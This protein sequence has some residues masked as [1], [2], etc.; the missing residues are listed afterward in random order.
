MSLFD[1][2]FTNLFGDA[3]VAGKS[4]DYKSDYYLLT[5]KQADK[6]YWHERF[7]DM[8]ISMSQDSS[9]E[10]FIV[11]GGVISDSGSGQI[12]LSEGV[13]IGKD[14]SGNR[15][16]I[17]MPA[18]TNIDVPSAWKDN[19]QLWVIG[20]YDHKLGSS[21][22]NH[23]I[24]TSYHYQLEDTYYGDSDGL[25][26]TD[27]DDLFLAADPG[28]AMVIWGSFQMSA[29]DSFTNKEGER[30]RTFQL[31]Q[32]NGVNT[33]RNFLVSN[34]TERA[35]QTAGIPIY[36]ICW[37]PSLELFCGVGQNDG[38]LDAIIITSPDGINWTHVAV[39]APKLFNLNDVCW[40]ESLTLFVA[41]GDNDADAYILTSPDGATWTE[42]APTV[43]KALALYGVC[44]SEEL[45]LFV[46]VGENDGA[47][48]Y[49]L[50]SPDGTTWTERTGGAKNKS[51][52]SV[53]WSPELTLF[54]AVGENDGGGDAYILT[55]PD[56]TTWTERANGKAFDLNGVCWSSALGL[57]CAV[58]VADGGDAY[59]L[60]S[61]NGTTW[62]ERANGKNFGLE[63]VCWSPVLS[64]FCAVGVADGVD[65]YLLTSPDGITWTE[66]KNGKNFG[67]NSVCWSPFFK[68]F[69][70][71]GAGDGV[72]AYLLTSLLN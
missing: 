57:F 27:S 47:E 64:L 33:I 12:D 13:A 31:N 14:T 6:N 71:G 21:T 60:T 49:I 2:V 58:G 20:K 29:G 17:Y 42:R 56:G 18:L 41:V 63:G 45:T 59:I 46:A 37:S 38:I 48:A 5:D 24:G 23:Y 3:E 68:L 28:D 62:T 67:L 54:V 1:S 61:P 32:S 25:N 43:A 7:C 39:A 4:P 34:W 51:L 69:C 16:L 36:G 53:C 66:R 30:T 11:Y 10:F 26:S 15:R 19:R 65:A 55:S 44:W 9:K 22:R 72:D 50:T 35:S 70:T 8:L 52:Y 40:S